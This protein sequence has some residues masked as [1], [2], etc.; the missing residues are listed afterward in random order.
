MRESSDRGVPT[1]VSPHLKRFRLASFTLA[2]EDVRS[3]SSLQ[4]EAQSEHGSL[5]NMLIC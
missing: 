1:L 5:A 4:I 2:S 3:P